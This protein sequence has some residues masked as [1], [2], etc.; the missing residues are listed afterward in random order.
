MEVFNEGKM[1][2]ILENF[3]K[4]VLVNMVVFRKNDSKKNCES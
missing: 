1:S 2:K 3:K 4:F